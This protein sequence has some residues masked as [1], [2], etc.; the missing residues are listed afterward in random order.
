MTDF[1]PEKTGDKS[2]RWE[3]LDP[4]CQSRVATRSLRGLDR[5]FTRARKRVSLFLLTGLIE[6]QQSHVL[7]GYYSPRQNSAPPR[8]YHGDAAGHATKVLYVAA[9]N[10]RRDSE[11]SY[12][13]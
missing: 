7:L 3:P 13:W 8:N 4:R 9:S 6:P 10:R 1:D 5:Q 12:L 2:L 11:V